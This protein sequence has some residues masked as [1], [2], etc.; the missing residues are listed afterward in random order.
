M[1]F[2]TGVLLWLGS[3]L[4][5]AFLIPTGPSAWPLREALQ[6]RSNRLLRYHNILSEKNES[7]DPKWNPKNHPKLDPLED[8]YKVLEVNPDC[9]E[10]E[11]KRAY[12]KLVIKYHPDN[13][14]SQT[15]KELANYQ[16]MVINNSYRVLK[17]ALLRA[18][19]DQI[20]TKQILASAD[21]SFAREGATKTAPNSVA[22]PSPSINKEKIEIPFEA[23]KRFLEEIYERKFS[24]DSTFVLDLYRRMQ[25]DTE[26]REN[27]IRNGDFHGPLSTSS[28]AAPSSAMQ[29][30]AEGFMVT[31]GDESLTS[32]KKYLTSLQRRKALK[33]NALRANSRDWGDVKDIQ[34]I[35]ARLQAIDE[36]RD[37]G[38]EIQRLHDE[39]QMLE[40]QTYDL[41]QSYSEEREY[42][43]KKQSVD[44]ERYRH[45]REAH[46]RSD[47]EGEPQ[48]Q[49]QS[50][51]NSNQKKKVD[52]W[53][54][55]SSYGPRWRENQ[56]NRRSGR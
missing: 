36:L 4:V 20:R 18:K 54:D 51:H 41:Q 53:D 52:F 25:T 14:S 31:R 1:Q 21:I 3:Y 34:L 9:T 39:I 46:L 2:L 43:Q 6:R 38:Q 7:G 37:L 56:R 12:Y 48:P 16:M 10:K 45:F 26:F 27:I 13:K 30:E 44:E 22:S 40:Y 35:T 42:W 11:L 47:G 55:D 19:Y 15:E 23:F 29:K 24:A 50:Q 5:T 28:T 8:Y 49:P 33:E 17:D 32:L